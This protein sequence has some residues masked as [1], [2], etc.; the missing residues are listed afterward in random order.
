MRVALDGALS[1]VF[2]VWCAGC[3]EP[4]AALCAACRQH[5]VPQARARTVEDLEVWSG[6]DFDGVAARVLRAAKEEGRTALLRALAP[7]LAAA[8][9]EALAHAPPVPVCLVPVPSSPAALRRR[10][11]RVVE[12]LTTRA[13]LPTER[14]VRTG[15][16]AADQ[17]GL[18]RQERAQNV[19]GRMTA[20]GADGRA[21]LIVDD[22]VTTGATLLETAR[23]LT[24]AGARVVGAATVASTPLHSPRRGFGTAT[25]R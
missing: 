14:L 2:P 8:V 3:D 21:V 10:G 11:F 19:A 20:R 18:G 23:A 25:D 16:R 5:L 15:G 1:L 13:G 22:V 6:L 7:A 24:A 17:R 12:V 4:D 9:D